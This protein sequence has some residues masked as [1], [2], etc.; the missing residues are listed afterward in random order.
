MFDEIPAQLVRLSKRIADVPVVK[1]LLDTITEEFAARRRRDVS[2]DGFREVQD[3]GANPGNLKMHVYDPASAAPA[4][5]PMVVLLHGCTQD[6]RQFAADSG[7]MAMA[8]RTGAVLIAPEQVSANNRGCC[9]NWF[10]P[11]DVQRGGGEMLSIRSM[12]AEAGRRYH[13]NMRRVYVVG[14][15]AGGAMAAACLA[16][17]PDVFAAG[18]V[19]AGLPAGGARTLTSALGLMNGNSMH[20]SP[21]ELAA[22]ARSLG[23]LE[24]NATLP[25]LTIWQGTADRTVSAHNADALVSQWTTLL[26]LPSASTREEQVGHAVRHRI[27]DRDGRRMV[28]S[29]TIDAMAHGYP[30]AGNGAPQRFVLTAPVDATPAIA[31]FWGL[32]DA[33]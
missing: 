22:E 6:P 30:V 20:R 1:R 27:W 13:C 29:W 19:V 10:R 28:E 23:G 33:G 11:G 9:F 18:A 4:L 14:L 24:S 31:R 21:A 32:L 15:S 12:I 25:P 2:L 5:A 8:A 3:F 26:G 7:W 17:Y 16:A